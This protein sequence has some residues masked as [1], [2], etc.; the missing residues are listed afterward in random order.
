M[1]ERWMKRFAPRGHCRLA[2]SRTTVT[3]RRVGASRKVPAL[4]VERPLAQT[5][6]PEMLAASIG[7]ALEESGGHGLPVHARFAD[8]LARYFI[9]T[10]AENS[11]RLQDLRAAAEVRL[12]RLYG[13]DPARWQIMADWQAAEP[14]LACAVSRDWAGALQAG[15][16]AAR[17]CLVS[18]MPA[19]VAAWNRS[20]REL[21]PGTWL[22]TRG[23]RAMT[24]GLIGAAPRA[25]LTAV[26]TLALPEPVP[27]LG[28]LRQQV[29]RMAL[30]DNLPAPAALLL[31]GPRCEPWLPGAADFTEPG[32]TVRWAEPDEWDESAERASAGGGPLAE[33]ATP[34]AWSGT[35]R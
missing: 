14:F 4:F 8:E 27:S 35:A 3:V 20:C 5:S 12:R 6:T 2:L 18:A 21:D 29:T 28:W 30:L 33:S 24:L 11:R 19:F 16:A 26:R 13:D 34:L 23:E 10:P 15:V 25:R 7:A 1:L 31:H 9:V 17:G 32:L 22:A